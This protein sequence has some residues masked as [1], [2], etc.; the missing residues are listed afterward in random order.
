VQSNYRD[1]HSSFIYIGHRTYNFRNEDSA[2]VYGNESTGYYLVLNG[3]IMPNT[4]G[5]P[6][7]P[8]WRFES[9]GIAVAELMIS[10]PSATANCF[11]KGLRLLNAIVIC[12]LNTNASAHSA[13]G[14]G[15]GG[16]RPE[17][18]ASK[19]TYAYHSSPPLRGVSLICVQTPPHN[20]GINLVS[21]G[22][23]GT[24]PS[25]DLS[26]LVMYHMSAH[27]RI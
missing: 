8:Q 26:E 15:V 27:D 25:A 5:F 9:L 6:F 3:I 21:S 4:M 2:I 20:G 22:Q 10:L 19:K 24:T 18:W 1:L 7:S 17:S 14:D 11:D 23:G 12:V 13:S 16:R